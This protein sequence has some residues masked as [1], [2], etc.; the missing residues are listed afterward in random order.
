MAVLARKEFHITVSIF[1]RD[2]DQTLFT[3]LVSIT[4]GDEQKPFVNIVTSEEFPNVIDAKRCGIE[5]G[6][7]WIKNRA[8]N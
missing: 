1:P 3:P 6:Q 7:R 8:P 2:F 5:M 4:S